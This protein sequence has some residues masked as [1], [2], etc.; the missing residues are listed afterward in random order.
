MSIPKLICNEYKLEIC[1]QI[2]L[3]TI[4]NGSNIVYN[5]IRVKDKNKGDDEMTVYVVVRDGSFLRA[6]TKRDEAVEYME[7]QKR[8]DEV[9]G[10]KWGY[11]PGKFSI[12]PL[13]HRDAAALL[14]K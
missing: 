4:D 1:S 14:D 7:E 3:K 12:R 11:T 6:Y 13:T 8:F 5:V 2:R 9:N 10:P